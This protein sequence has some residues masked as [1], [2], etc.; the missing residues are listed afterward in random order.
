RKRHETSA[1]S[2]SAA[3]SG[4]LRAAGTSADPEGAE[5][6][7]A[8]HT[9][10]GSIPAGRGVRHHRS[11]VG[12]PNE[13]FVRRGRHPEQRRQGRVGAAAADAGRAGPGGSTPRPGGATPHIT[14]ALLKTRPQFA[15][16]KDLEPIP[17]TAIPAFALAVYPS[18]PA[19]NLNELV[20]YAKANPGKLSY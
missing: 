1:P 2:I 12:G 15:P 3:G 17:D 8:A 6:S 11:P 5:L 13:I 14:E 10:R 18:V 7:D 9:P 16:L 20:A 19:N 4:R